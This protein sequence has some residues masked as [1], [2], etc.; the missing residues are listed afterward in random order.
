MFTSAAERLFLRH[1]SQPFTTVIPNVCPFPFLRAGAT[2]P[3]PCQ[4]SRARP[5]GTSFP[6][7][8]E[9]VRS[10]A[11]QPENWAWLDDF[12]C[13]QNDC[14]KAQEILQCRATKLL[15]NRAPGEGRKGGS[16]FLHPAS[17]SFP[18]CT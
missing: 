15:P 4:H 14:F 17:A 13:S 5:P 10:E 9:T 18:F 16:C 1:T 12:S 7:V 6:C 2:L 8:W 11:N 3:S